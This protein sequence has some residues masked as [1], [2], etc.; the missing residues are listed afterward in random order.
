MR[1]FF[2]VLLVAALIGGGG[3]YWYATHKDG[4]GS[5]TA[6]ADAPKAPAGA[7]RTVPV[8]T[9]TV[10][11]QAV[12]EQIVTI[13]S[14]QPIAAI[15]IKP[16][17]DSAVET[18]A[19]TEGQEVKTGDTLFT[20]DSRS[21]DAQLRQA[22]AN[23]ERDRANLEKAK[24]DVKRYAELVRTSA[25]S[26]TTYDA[27]VAT[28]DALEG[29]VKADLAAIEAAKVSLS[30]TRITAPMDGRTGAVNAKVGAMVRA[31]DANPLVT[32][33]QLRPINVSF[34]V[35][36]KHLPAIRAAMANGSLPVT[37]SIA[38]GHGQ[39]PGG[40][41]AEGKLSFV[42]SQVDQQTGTILVKGEFPNADTRL[43]PGQFVDT[44]LT[45]RV[46]QNALT[47]PDLAVQTGQKGRF[48][49]VVK[50]DE[51]VEVRPVTVERSHG[52]LSVVASGLK[53]GERVVVD[54]Q[55][56]LF[57]GAKITEKAGG[58]PAAPTSGGE[59]AE[60]GRQ[61]G[62]ATQDAAARSTI[63]Q[64]KSTGGAT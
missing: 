55:S 39:N 5:K 21:L 57:P 49:Y 32:L 3:Y 59:T 41:K 62:S 19:F 33:T 43:W 9:Q 46:E 54:G 53:A 4:A 29:T 44:V 6:A 40:E 24:G 23:L 61:Q 10:A 37:A 58:K 36:E 63:T 16:R 15:A 34:N 45:L 26:R 7:G 42:D 20:L 64:G 27:A 28:A 30:F 18:V 12:P 2:W 51:T 14:V 35:P 48:V 31:A 56:R 13:G 11:T 25:I 47:I 8:V 22:Q 1:R 17:V 60:G 52:G 50:A 38:G